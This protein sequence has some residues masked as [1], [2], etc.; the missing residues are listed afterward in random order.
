MTALP[1]IA[2]A[3]TLALWLLAPTPALAASAP[4]RQDVQD[5]LERSVAA[6][7]PGAT[8]VIRGPGGVERYAAGVADLQR[9]VPLLT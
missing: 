9:H 4:S 7:I 6:G 1:G 3:T 2:V 5:A 8:A